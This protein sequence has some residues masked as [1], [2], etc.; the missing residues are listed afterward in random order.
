[1]LLIYRCALL[2]VFITLVYAEL[3][4]LLQNNIVTVKQALIALDVKQIVRSV[5]FLEG[6]NS[7][8]Y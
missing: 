5:S 6:E 4:F 1:M 2:L 7:R 3:A 8:A